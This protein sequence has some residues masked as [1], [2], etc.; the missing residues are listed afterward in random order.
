MDDNV[1]QGD[2]SNA[3]MSQGV[4]VELKRAPEPKARKTLASIKREPCVPKRR[5]GVA[6]P[7]VAT[8]ARPPKAPKPLRRKLRPAARN[9]DLGEASSAA[10]DSKH[11][12]HIIPLNAHPSTVVIQPW[13][14]HGAGP[15]IGFCAI[16]GRVQ[17]MDE[18][19]CGSPVKGGTCGSN[20]E[21]PRHVFP[22]A[23]RAA[24]SVNAASKGATATAVKS[25]KLR[26][27]CL[28][29]KGVPIQE[30]LLEPTERTTRSVG[31]GTVP[32]VVRRKEN[33]ARRLSKCEIVAQCTA[34]DMPLTDPDCGVSLPRIRATTGRRRN[35][36][37][38]FKSQPFNNREPR[39]RSSDYRAT[40][41]AFMSPRYKQKE[42]EVYDIFSPKLAGPS[43]STT[44]EAS[45]S[46]ERNLENSVREVHAQ[47]GDEKIANL[48]C[49]DS[50]AKE[51]P[52]STV[53]DNSLLETTV[54]G[55]LTR[56]SGNSQQ[57]KKDLLVFHVIILVAVTGAAALA[58]AFYPGA[59]KSSSGFP[60]IIE[61][62]F[63]ASV[64][65]TTS[66]TSTKH[67][68]DAP[69]H[70]VH[71]EPLYDVCST[72]TC[73]KDGAYLGALISKNMDPCDDFYKF[74]CSRWK[75]ANGST[76]PDDELVQKLESDIYHVLSSPLS[77]SVQ[78]SD[79]LS[80]LKR[81]MT[82][83]MNGVNRTNV[84][85]VLD[86]LAAAD[87]EGFPFT[88]PVRSS[89][90]PW[91]TAAKVFL[92]T[93]TS[94]LLR[95]GVALHPFE[96]D[97]DIIT[98]E[99]PEPLIVGP[100]K[101]T[102]AY[103]RLMQASMNALGKR[104]VPSSYA[105]EVVAFTQQL[106]AAIASGESQSRDE[107]SHRVVK[108]KEENELQVYL[109]EVFGDLQLP[110]EEED[111]DLMLLSPDFSRALV[112]LIRKT[113]VHVILN[114]LCV[115]VLVRSSV[116][117]SMADQDLEWAV[118]AQLF[119]RPVRHVQRWRL[120]VRAA[121]Q[122]L[123][124]LFLYATHLVV[125]TADSTISGL[126]DNVLK[127]VITHVESLI[128]LD[129]QTRVLAKRI[130]S[131]VRFLVGLPHWL[132]DM[133]KL[134]SFVAKLPLFNNRSNFLKWLSEVNE[135]VQT[136][137][138]RRSSREFWRASP[139]ETDCWY[140]LQLKT[141]YIPVLLA[142]WTRYR[143]DELGYLQL[144]RQGHRAAR[145]VL[146]MLFEGVSSFFNREILTRSFWSSSAKTSLRRAQLCLQEHARVPASMSL[147]LLEDHTAL[148]V[149][150]E[151]YQGNVHL[152]GAATAS[153]AIRD[154]RLPGA[155]DFTADHLFFIYYSLDF[156]NSDLREEELEDRARLVNIPLRGSLM[157]HEVYGCRPTSK[158]GPLDK[159]TAWVSAAKQS[160]S[161]IS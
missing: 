160:G 114:F 103:R 53:S 94:A 110:P 123:P 99:V 111:R 63:P 7:T 58:I 134:S 9:N 86:L 153:G 146:K 85:P 139:F 23:R 108:L 100:E 40:E 132:S 22:V 145:C 152:V 18:D 67:P 10:R 144:P 12:K 31:A 48:P 59:V 91:K 75:G 131:D 35:D 21:K 158:M 41:V 126:L 102:S 118:S 138:L 157:F 95:L 39:G 24:I 151:L 42:N 49:A 62:G 15:R 88:P 50:S 65:S 121:A 68:M 28:P 2:K 38:T 77:L 143:V 115:H 17:L 45:T 69:E 47:R 83:C 33:S 52:A 56:G 141:V 97:I 81:V 89:I 36:E 13:D 140:D 29:V 101:T 25:R 150:Q 112:H 16:K 120:C 26:P 76:S 128:F 30:R 72:E 66:S 137:T 161:M 106:D 113:D 82:A 127:Q 32:T 14:S 27:S 79:V 130:L 19:L 107:R 135:M 73:Q 87:L 20:E 80:P 57:L 142:N 5:G 1:S 60:L 149:I 124:D 11:S 70:V 78:D 155:E 156:C 6:A 136:S 51:T 105:M 64:S 44:A 8:S 74:V 92:L 154:V 4:H 125:K 54:S 55:N 159:C 104:F 133:S 84:D 90:S 148:K 96:P 119:N 46:L 71:R 129:G 43:W 147:S 116:F 117:V 3:E 109:L 122:A 61:R 37:C 98:V 93:G 34:G